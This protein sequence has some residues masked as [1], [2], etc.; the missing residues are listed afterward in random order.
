MNINY[1]VNLKLLAVFLFIFAGVFSLPVYAVDVSACGTLSS[2]N[3]V[4]T[5]TQDI[6]T[7]ST[8]FIITADNVT[9]DLNGHE[10]SDHNHQTNYGV[11]SI[12]NNYLTIKNGYIYNF[13]D[14][15]YFK[16]SSNNIIFNVTSNMNY[17]GILFSSVSFSEIINCTAES[18]NENIHLTSD[19]AYNLIQGNNL[20]LGTYSIWLSQSP[21]NNQIIANN[22]DSSQFGIAI[23][24]CESNTISNNNIQNCS[25]NGIYP[26]IL[27]NRCDKNIFSNNI[28][29]GSNGYGIRITSL[30]PVGHA[31]D[32]MFKNNVV[33]GIASDNVI[34]EDQT[35]SINANNTFLN[36]TYQ[37]ESVDTNSEL[38]R[39]WYLDVNVSGNS[40][41]QGA[42]VTAWNSIGQQVFSELTGADGRIPTQ[43][44]IEYK[45]IAG[46]KSYATPY[47][48][49][50][51]K[52]GYDTEARQVNLDTNVFLDVEL[53]EEPQTTTTTTIPTTTSTTTSIATTTTTTIEE[54]Q[55]TTTIEEPQTTTTTIQESC[56]DSDDGKNYYEAGSVILEKN[57]KAL[58]KEDTCVNKWGLLREYYCMTGSNKFYTSYYICPNGC[59]NGACVEEQNVFKNRFTWLNPF[60]NFIS[61]FSKSRFA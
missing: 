58:V 57:K 60:L 48:V 13:Y 18:N 33:S 12:G 10:I 24:F 17:R 31:S 51:S 23:N 45:N 21:H 46:T 34:L 3:T 39:K 5:L 61:R 19:S 36:T 56:I 50:V 20:R 9:L 54:P 37:N 27:V 2:A 30:G 14:G 42:T 6:I 4:Y 38:I 26:C 55:T 41:V 25:S 28:I 7:N 44:L 15:I 40:P 32:N 8:C 59:V 11:Y 22:I 29:S 16:F 52:D 53:N 35:G 1:F 43:K 47:I 49:N